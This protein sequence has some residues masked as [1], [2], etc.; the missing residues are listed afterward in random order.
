MNPK[1]QMMYNRGLVTTTNCKKYLPLGANPNSFDTIFGRSV[2][3]K[4]T[5]NTDT[6]IENVKLLFEYGANPNIK[7]VNGN[8]PL[9]DVINIEIIDL[10]IRHGLNPFMTNYE[11][12]SALHLSLFYN[13]AIYIREHLV[14]LGCV[15]WF[16]HY[17]IEKSSRWKSNDRTVNNLM[18]LLSVYWKVLPVDMFR[19]VGYRLVFKN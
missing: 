3:H 6:D 10:L 16:D 8:T 11:G 17:T 14:K 2:L 15:M 9:F 5:S 18:A 7:D 4:C 19:L 12:F 13:R 1:L